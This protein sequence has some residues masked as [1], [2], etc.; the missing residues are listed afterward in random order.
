M[1]RW[2]STWLLGS[3]QGRLTFISVIVLPII[4]G[5]LA[6]TLD[7]A[8]SAS[9]LKSQE[10]Q[11]L[12]QV[13]SLIAS[14]ELNE[15]SLWLPEL[16]TDDQFNQTSSD[17]YALVFGSAST[18]VLWRSLSTKASD[19]DHYL[20]KT[21]LSPGLPNFSL[22]SDAQQ[23]LFV[24]NYLTEW[25]DE[26]GI[27]PFRFVVIQTQE[28]YQETVRE[29]RKT[30]WFWLGLM[31][32]ALVLVQVM[33]LKWGFKPVASL[34]RDLA[35]IQKGEATAL[36]GAYPLELN[37]MT[38]SLNR[39]LEHEAHQRERYRN[40]L[41]DLAHS[42]KNPSAII[43]SA[44]SNVKRKEDSET[45][46]YLADIEEQNKRIDQILSYQLTKAVGGAATPFGR[47]IAVKPHCEKIISAM[48][49]V[50]YD[51]S[52]VLQAELDDLASFKGDEGDL[53]ELLGNLIDNAFKYGKSVVRIG[54]QG[55]D[56]TLEIRVEDDGPG[57][58]EAER[59][60]LIRRGQRADTSIPGQGIGLAVV[61]DIVKSYAGEWHLGQSELG[62]LAVV[63]NFRRS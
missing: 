58:T 9:L 59:V 36:K 47:S 3:I 26:A 42:I 34:S 15:G 17:T 40:T 43:A 8:F 6:W 54:I 16:L 18:Q 46:S 10:R 39:L 55:N 30:L 4:C 25:E 22:V 53:M 63:L 61:N 57:M 45:S 14:A 48:Q 28:A 49:K 50:Y 20:T 51:K 37:D 41:A 1:K 19:T 29:Y 35:L 23:P 11:M 12:S 31:A 27:H 52:I 60:N 2:L 56:N 33:I 32:S 38:H 13:Y 44:L 5:A 7:R 62:G 21:K 24:L